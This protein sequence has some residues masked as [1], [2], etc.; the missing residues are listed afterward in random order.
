MKQTA[1]V[2]MTYA[3]DVSGVCSA[4]YELGGMTIMHDASGCNSTYNTHD[5]P[6]WYHTPSMV[7]ISA[8]SE[9]EAVL[10][11]DGKLIRD[12][13]DAARELHPRFIAIAGTPI[14]MMMGTDF[15]GIARLIERETGIPT[16]GFATNGM[17]DYGVGAGM[18]LEA[19]AGRFC[20]PSVQPESGLSINLLGVTPLDFSV[21]GNVEALRNVFESAGIPVKSCWAMGSSFDELMC[22]GKA[23]VNVAVSACG[24]PLAKRLKKIY[25]TPYV[26]G[27]PIGKSGAAALIAA[28]EKADAS[29]EDQFPMRAVS[30]AK[31]GKI[32][33]A[34]EAVQAGSLR[35]ALERELGLSDI[36]VVCPMEAAEELFLPGDQ[37]MGEEDDVF[38]VFR[39]AET[40]VG[41]PLFGRAIRGGAARLIRLPHE[42]FSGRIYRKEIPVLMG[43]QGTKWIQKEFNR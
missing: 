2:L 17:H 29:G 11:D 42:G 3:A 31:D 25:G 35:Y 38:A 39:E 26:A 24:L 19:V 28:I 43:D 15:S 22:A 7:Y 37:R 6:R 18:A 16:F 4:L 40:V 5:E 32:V 23:R 21:T 34:G 8:L 10:G 41:D 33:I 9:L 14:P 30:G 27:L 36:R 1:S 12:I 13:E 20:D